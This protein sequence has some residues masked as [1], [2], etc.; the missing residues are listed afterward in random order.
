MPLNVMYLGDALT[1]LW[2]ILLI[3]SMKRI[4]YNFVEILRDVNGTLIEQ[5][6]QSVVLLL[7]VEILPMKD[8]RLVYLAKSVVQWNP[9]AILKAF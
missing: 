8:V 4:V 9:S 1:A 6:I 7:A 2:W 3:N 5:K